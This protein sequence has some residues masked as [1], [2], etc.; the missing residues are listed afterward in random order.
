VNCVEHISF[1]HIL[2]SSSQTATVP[3]REVGTRSIRV[4]ERK[5]EANARSTTVTT[6]VASEMRLAAIRMSIKAEA[7]NAVQEVTAKLTFN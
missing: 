3:A 6:A 4:I 7:V 2:T 1:R 5:P